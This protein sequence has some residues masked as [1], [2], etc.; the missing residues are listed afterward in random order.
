MLG[1]ERRVMYQL[2]KSKDYRVEGDSQIKM[3]ALA[4]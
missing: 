1:H 3:C 2:N 4:S